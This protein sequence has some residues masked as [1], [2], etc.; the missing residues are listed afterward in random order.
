MASLLDRDILCKGQLKMGLLPI[1]DVR[2]YTKEAMSLE[3][4]RTIDQGRWTSSPIII[5]IYVAAGF[6]NMIEPVRSIV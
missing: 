1:K 3:E 4:R 6:N 2:A 5:M